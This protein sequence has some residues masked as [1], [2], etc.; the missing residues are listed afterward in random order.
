MQVSLPY[1]SSESVIF[2][3]YISVSHD[4]VSLVPPSGFYQRWTCLKLDY[5]S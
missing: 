5:R 2:A 3:L 4:L 1:P